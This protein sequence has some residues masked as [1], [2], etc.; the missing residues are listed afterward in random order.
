MYLSHSTHKNIFVPALQ[1]RRLIKN[2]S[3]LAVIILW[4]VNGT[5]AQNN[6]NVRMWP[7]DINNN[8]IVNNID[9]LYWAVAKGSTG[10][11]RR[12]ARTFWITQALPDP[13]WT[14]TFP[15]G[16]NYAYADCNG[17]GV[18]DDD[19][20][21]VIDRNFGEVHGEV[22]PDVFSNSQ[23]DTIPTLLIST[24]SPIVPPGGT[25]I[26]DLSLGTASDTI[27]D[28]FGLSFTIVY[29]PD[30][31]GE[32]DEDDVFSFEIEEDSWL[33]EEEDNIEDELVTF[34]KNDRNLGLA[35][36]TIARNDGRTV[37]GFGKIGTFN[38]V[39][40]DIVFLNTTI[41]NTDIS[42]IDEELISKEVAPSN[43]EF[44]I[45][46][47]SS[48]NNPITNRGLKLF[49][50][51]VNGAVINIALEN[52]KEGIRL[53]QLFDTNGRLLVTQRYEHRT[54]NK[55]FDIND[56][57]NGVYTFKIITDKHLYVQSFVRQK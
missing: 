34:I 12:N 31:L 1:M 45:T 44:S 48:S 15:N 57:P 37:T 56:Y 28:F 43:V 14:G 11:T 23:G 42:L 35:Q 24:E 5:F 53:V 9:V 6:N 25:L 50:N 55:E 8:G 3:L 52:P 54:S 29:D 2:I 38:I 49:P 16:L 26:A 51:P 7:G 30:I 13:L 27:N 22:V 17:D 39:M 40:E 21:A 36:I 10:P 47:A 4:Q 18:V 19:D 32:D 33:V 20:R 46:N 41:G